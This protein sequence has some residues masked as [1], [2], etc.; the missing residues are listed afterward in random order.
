MTGSED[1]AIALTRVGERIA[2]CA[3]CP[4]LVRWRREV[5]DAPPARHAGE[6]YWARP[7]PGFGDPRARICVLGL[8]TAAHGGNR[9]GRAFTGNPT[10]DWVVRALHRAG[11]ANQPTSRHRGDGLRLEG[12]WAGSVVRCAPPG[13]RPTPVERD[14]CLAHLSEEVA[15]LA[16]LRVL[17]A[18]GGFAWDAVARWAGAR[19]KPRF[20]HGVEHRLDSGL[21]LLGGYHPSRQ[22]TNT[23]VLTEAMLDAVL[24]RA[25]DIA[26]P[27]RAGVT[28]VR[29]AGPG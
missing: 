28:G 8:A 17:V 2:S 19:P 4:R 14:T 15:A 10:G 24:A 13:N 9:T 22:N 11:L 7:V 29:L 5:A 20:G 23:G 12:A 26:W 16:E 25:V 21:V 18:L 27:R 6:R 1:G 3:L